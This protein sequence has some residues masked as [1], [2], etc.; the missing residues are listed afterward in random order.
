MDLE[1]VGIIPNT[2][3]DESPTIW[4]DAA[5]GDLIIQSYKA[6]AETIRAAQ[7]VGSIPGHSTDIPDHETMIRLPEVMIQFLAPIVAQYLNQPHGVSES[8]TPGA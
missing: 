6:D 7:I 1:F 5:T 8:A 2:P 3:T 4:R